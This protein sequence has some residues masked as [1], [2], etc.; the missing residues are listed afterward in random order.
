M[1]PEKKDNLEKFNFKNLMTIAGVVIFTACCIILFYFIVQRYSGFS[2]GWNKFVKVWTGIIIGF[3]LA[4]L[5][6]PIMD[7]FEKKTL[8]FFLRHTRNE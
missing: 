4:F 2:E 1:E 8:P 3:V 6:N 5:M 7:F